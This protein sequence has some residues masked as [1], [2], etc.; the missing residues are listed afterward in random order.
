MSAKAAGE[1]WWVP[2]L[3]TRAPS[4][5]VRAGCGP[6]EVAEVVG[7]NCCSKPWA[8]RVRGAQRP[9]LVRAT[10]VLCE[11]SR[12]RARLSRTG[13]FGARE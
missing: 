11:E 9:T 4:A 6:V 13:R 2:E 7:G 8:V 1:A 5:A 12:G 3:T 10:P